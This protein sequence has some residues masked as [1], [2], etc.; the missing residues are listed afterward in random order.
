MN[1]NYL[2]FLDERIKKFK[3]KN[4]RVEKIKNLLAAEKYK[5]QQQM[6]MH[7]LFHVTQIT[8]TSNESTNTNSNKMN[9]TKSTSNK[10]QFLNDNETFSFQGKIKVLPNDNKN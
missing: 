3:K 7:T 2:K 4:K 5:K 9:I 6:N 8:T 1:N 10:S